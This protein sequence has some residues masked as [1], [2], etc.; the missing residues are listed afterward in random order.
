VASGRP[1]PN[2]RTSGG[3]SCAASSHRVARR[4]AERGRTPISF[5]RST[6]RKGPID[7]DQRQRQRDPAN[8]IIMNVMNRTR[9][10]TSPIVPV[11]VWTP[12]IG[13]SGTT[14]RMRLRARDPR[15]PDQRTRTVSFSARPSPLAARS[16]SERSVAIDPAAVRRRRADRSAGLPRSPD[17]RRQRSRR[18][19]RTASERLPT[20]RTGG[21]GRVALVVRPPI[22]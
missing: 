14:R 15:A 20:A 5:R 8:P 7:T 3:R 2:V 10:F 21:G 6:A 18:P 22:N 4:R 13:T 12:T 19:R 9:A 11:A 17:S 16:S 1:I